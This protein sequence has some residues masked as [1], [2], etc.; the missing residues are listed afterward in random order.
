M[1]TDDGK[2]LPFGGPLLI[3]EK[4]PKIFE[5][6]GLGESFFAEDILGERFLLF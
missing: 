5:T 4:E 2:L 6:E 1:R 3:A